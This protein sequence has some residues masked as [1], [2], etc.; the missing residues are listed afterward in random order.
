MRRPAESRF[1]FFGLVTFLLGA[2]A[3]ALRDWQYV[4]IIAIACLVFALY[5]AL[6]EYRGVFPTAHDAALEEAA[7]VVE[8]Q[9]CLLLAS[10]TGEEE[11]DEYKKAICFQLTMQALA[12]RKRKIHRGKL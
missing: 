6:Q 9:T 5:T 1:Y 11:A 3:H 4:M 2:A 12:I 7:K 10:M 8:G